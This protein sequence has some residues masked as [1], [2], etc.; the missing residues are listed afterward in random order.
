MELCIIESMIPLDDDI[1]TSYMPIKYGFKA[2]LLCESI[3]GYVLNWE[4]HK[5]KDEEEHGKIVQF[6]TEPYLNEGFHI[7]MDRYHSHPKVFRFLQ[8]NN[9]GVIDTVMLNRFSLPNKIKEKLE[10]M[11][12]NEILHFQYGESMLLSTR[13]NAKLVSVLSTIHKHETVSV[14]KLSKK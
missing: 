13:K 3:T 12:K 11:K 10:K 5:T 9:C 6:L 4:L 8:A 1:N 7:Y 14:E 2:Y